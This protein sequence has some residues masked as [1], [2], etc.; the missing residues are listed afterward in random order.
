MSCSEFEASIRVIQTAGI[1]Y[2][3]AYMKFEFVTAVSVEIVVF[4]GRDICSYTEDG[5]RNFYRNLNK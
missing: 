4:L 1:T 5:G 3:F 2:I